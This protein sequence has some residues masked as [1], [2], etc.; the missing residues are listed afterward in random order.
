VRWFLLILIA[1]AVAAVYPPFGILVAAV[2]A[3]YAHTS[4]ASWVRNSLI[5][6][7]LVVLAWFI[8]GFGSDVPYSRFEEGTSALEPGPMTAMRTT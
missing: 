1:I 3:V 4:G 6:V 2:G 5:V 8:A 7:T